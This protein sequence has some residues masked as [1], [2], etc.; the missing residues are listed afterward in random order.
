MY[1]AIKFIEDNLKED[2]SIADIADAVY[3]SLYHFC[4]TFNKVIHHTPYD[5]LIRRRLSE[6]AF[7]LLNTDKKI[8]EIAFDH[9]FNNAET[10]SRAFKRMFGVQPI[11]WKKQTN[12]AHCLLLPRF[13]YEYI[14]HINKGNYLRPV[15]KE[16][17]SFNILGLMT[18]I[19]KKQDKINLIWDELSSEL[20]RIEQITKV[21]NYYGIRFYST[22]HCDN[23]HLYLVG[24][25][26]QYPEEIISS[27]IYKSIP[28][29]NYAKF[30]HKGDLTHRHYT[31][32]YIYKTWLPK[33]GFQLH[34]PL[35]V[36]YYGQ[37]LPNHSQFNSEVNIYIPI[38][39][40]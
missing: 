23:R 25:E 12:S 3:F 2:I 9:Q 29:L 22:N 30:I 14:E 19:E 16:K 34:H 20:Q 5:Y 31:S 13:T 33:S 15:L 21:N 17:Q 37:Y 40:S 35:E 18:Y 26:I 6:S 8:I 1:K 39:N 7:E 38:K 24:A 32:D 11:Q 10:F 36:E 28:S 4:R 27:L